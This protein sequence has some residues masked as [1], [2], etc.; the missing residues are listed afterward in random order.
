MDLQR[1]ATRIYACPL[2]GIDTAHRVTGNRDTTYG[3]MCSHCGGGSIVDGYVLQRYQTEWE[4]TLREVLE[5]LGEY[6]DE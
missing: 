5:D 6:D 4:Q 1:G 2:C 3:I